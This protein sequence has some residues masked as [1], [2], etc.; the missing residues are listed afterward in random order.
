MMLF[1]LISQFAISAGCDPNKTFFGLPVWYKYLIKAPSG[2]ACDFR[3]LRVWPPDNLGRYFIRVV[4][5]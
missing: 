1:T 5:G 2:G 4:P 3:N